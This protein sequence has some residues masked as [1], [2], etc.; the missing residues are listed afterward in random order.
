MKKADKQRIAN[1]VRDAAVR[2]PNSIP[3]VKEYSG[4]VAAKFSPTSADQY[5]KLSEIVWWLIALDC[6][7]PA[8]GLLDSLCEVD[9]EYYWMFHALASTFATRAWLHAKRKE[10]APSRE[11]ARTAL[12]W[13]HRDPNSKAIGKSEVRDALDRFDGW[14]DRANRETRTVTA[15]HVISHSLRV[16]VMYQQFAAAGDPESKAVASREFTSRLNS[17]VQELQSRIEKW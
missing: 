10:H 12:H 3:K 17:G 13:V 9:D 8:M 7:E 2:I 1:L 5:R 16:L 4:K 11:D 15:L 6:D 14:L